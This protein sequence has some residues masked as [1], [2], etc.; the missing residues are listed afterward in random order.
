MTRLM[1][2]RRDKAGKR[3]R[4]P[5]FTVA[6]VVPVTLSALLAAQGTKSGNPEQH[7]PPNITQLTG[8][9][10]RAS[11][12]P[13]G[14]QIAF[15]SKS[16][17]DAF[18][19]DVSTKVIR[20]LTHYP[21]AGYLRVQYLPNGDVFLIGARTFTDIRTTRSRDQEMW[22]L[23]SGGTGQPLPLGHKI[24]EGVA[25]SRRKP[26][27]AWSNTHGQ[28][29][30]QIGE[31]ESVIYTAEIVEKGGVFALT[32]KK[33][34]NRAKA[35][36]CTLEAQDFRND[37]TELIY[38]CYRS[39]F[40]DVFGINLQTGVTTTY[41]KIAGEYNEVEGIFPNGRYA[42]VESSREQIQQDSN[43]IDIWKLTLEPN[44]TDF[45]RMTRWGD[46]PGFKAS[47][48]VVSRDG[49]T[50]A[51]QSARSSDPAGVGY[52]IYLLTLR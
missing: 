10:E 52:G 46:H 49:R 27:I 19:A 42:L 18:V 38:T 21:N 11:W 22:V 44:S 4:S 9:G 24:S 50:I 36:E 32:N 51:F 17:G 13:D 12:S 8:F 48:P 26:L 28:Y 47:N 33:E 16:F 20:L 5:G 15:M 6:L 37:D 43:H 7:L 14:R 2:D 34:I 1:T 23:K 45:V 31:G 41:R 3:R 30:D 35:P 25:I 29:P 40:A 39:P